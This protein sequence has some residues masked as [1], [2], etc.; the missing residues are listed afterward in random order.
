[1][2][3][4]LVWIAVEAGS[5]SGGPNPGR[6]VW[7]N[8]EGY[9]PIDW[10]FAIYPLIFTDLA[11]FC[12]L[13]HMVRTLLDNPFATTYPVFTYSSCSGMTVLELLLALLIL[14]ATLLS[15]YVSMRRVTAKGEEVRRRRT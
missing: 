10:N 6:L 3:G 1:M 15:L 13:C 7:D 14:Q 9:N 8:R 2:L 5:A 4:Q 11:K 12:D